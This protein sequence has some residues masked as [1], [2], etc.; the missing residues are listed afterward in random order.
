MLVKTQRVR[1]AIIRRISFSSRQFFS[2]VISDA[3][4]SRFVPGS[5]ILQPVARLKEC[6]DVLRRNFGLQHVRR[7]QHQP[8]I[9]RVEAFGDVAVYGEPVFA[10]DP[11]GMIDGV[12]GELEPFGRR[13]SGP[14]PVSQK[15]LPRKEI[16]NKRS[17]RPRFAKRLKNVCVS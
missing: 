3:G 11:P 16:G 10:M 9:P 7:G 12:I 1:V 6:D 13:Q 4:N 5:A 15:N 17:A 14:M 2:R 8:A